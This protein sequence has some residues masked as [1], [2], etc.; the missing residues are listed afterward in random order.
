MSVLKL[1]TLIKTSPYFML[2]Q[3]DKGESISM[4]YNPWRDNRVPLELLE[5]KDMDARRKVYRELNLQGCIK[6]S[7][8]E[9]EKLLLESQKYYR[10][11]LPYLDF[12]PF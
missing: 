8:Q 12:A 1:K 6:V 9:A 2:T 5:S 4:L 10:D 7:P 3:H 11:V